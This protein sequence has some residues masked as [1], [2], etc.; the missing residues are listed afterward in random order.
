MGKWINYKGGRPACIAWIARIFATQLGPDWRKSAT[1]VLV[2]FL[3]EEQDYGSQFNEVLQQEADI[4]ELEFLI[5]E[6]RTY[7]KPILKRKFCE[8]QDSYTKWQATGHTRCQ[9]RNF[10]KRL[11]RHNLQRSNRK[12]KRKIACARAAAVKTTS[13]GNIK[14]G[15][16]NAR[17]MGAPFGRDCSGKIQAITAVIA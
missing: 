9:R 3:L 2:S 4:Q 12:R 17:G 13:K 5:D 11:H 6:A 16:W 8:S 7:K 15:S 1:D 10:M 14:I